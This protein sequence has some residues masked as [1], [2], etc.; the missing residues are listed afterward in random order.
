MHLGADIMS[1][2][3][4]TNAALAMPRIARL[5]STILR[6]RR[7]GADRDA[8]WFTLPLETEGSCGRVCDFRYARDTQT[9]R[10]ADLLTHHIQRLRPGDP[11]LA[12]QEW[13]NQRLDV[14]ALQPSEQAEILDHLPVRRPVQPRQPGPVDL[15]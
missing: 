6:V 5:R 4:T 3:R 12:A 11:R 9:P 2:R 15:R 1:G 14:G 10:R 7:G 8:W 13:I